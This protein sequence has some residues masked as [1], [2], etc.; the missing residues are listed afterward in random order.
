VLIFDWPLQNL[1]QTIDNM[2]S[3]AA[4]FFTP[5]LELPLVG[6]SQRWATYAETVDV[7]PHLRYVI[8]RG[9]EGSAPEPI[10]L[11]QRAGYAILR[12]GFEID[13]DFD[14]SFFLFFTSAVHSAYH[15]HRDDLSF[16]LWAHGDN[17]LTDQGH[18]SYNVGDPYYEYAYAT[19]AHNT[20]LV[21]G[22]DWALV[23]ESYGQ[24]EILGLES[25]G[26]VHVIEARHRLYEG[27]EIHRTVRYEEPDRVFVVDNIRSA[28]CHDY[29]QL[30]HLHPDHGE[31]VDGNQVIVCGDG[32]HAMRLTLEGVDRV[33]TV[34]G[35]TSPEPW[36]WHYPEMGVRIPN[37][38][39]VGRFSGTDARV[40]T[41]IAFAPWDEWCAP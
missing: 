22:E 12:D 10:A 39:I 29:A 2:E 6:D 36:G 1:A 34:R 13:D 9:A 16:V 32:T 18:D 21:D 5:S 27:V 8:T 15:K 25:E 38:V 7:H 11:F 23:P 30:W 14:Q 26:G 19:R 24:S 37:T 40:E 35:Q 17:W 33:D 4:H 28:D 41:T 3:A 20:V 31:R